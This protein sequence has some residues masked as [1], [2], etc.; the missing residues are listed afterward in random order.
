MSSKIPT[1]PEPNAWDILSQK[2]TPERRA[3]IEKVVEHRT[4]HIRLVIQ[5]VHDPHNISACLRSAEAFGVYH[6]DI[7]T[8]LKT[9]K[10]STV[11]RGTVKWL[12]ISYWD[13]IE[14][15]ALNLKG[16]GY[17]LLTADPG[18]HLDSI[19]DVPVK[20]K[21]AIILGNEHSGTHSDW[22]TYI[23]GSF[24]IPV[25]G[26]VESLNISVAAALS[27]NILVERS[28]QALDPQSFY[29]SKEE[30]FR[31]FDKIARDH[32]RNPDTEIRLMT[33]HKPGHSSRT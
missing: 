3:R 16:L 5:D 17:R 19:W 2:L 9:F 21:T 11:A 7:V 30:R 6:V 22:K 25:V 23:D 8:V 4:N 10:P 18:E 27:L 1:D 20:Q 15:C 26:M 33:G 28:R 29:A 12:E 32:S 13:S 14:S 24:T 31:L